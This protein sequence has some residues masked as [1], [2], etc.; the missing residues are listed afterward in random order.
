M[1]MTSDRSETDCP[2]RDGRRCG[3]ID[4]HDIEEAAG[5]LRAGKLV[6]FPTET[7]YGLGA[8]A[9]DNRA[10]AAIFEAKGRPRFNPL[11]VHVAD[12]AQ[13]SSLAVWSALAERLAR[14]FWPGP[15]TLILP[16]PQDSSISML[17]SAGGDTIALRAPAHPVAEELLRRT[18]LP[19]TGPSANPSGRV[20]PTTVDHVVQGL[21][22]R[23]DLVIDGGPCAVGVES[24][25][26]DLTTSRPCLLRPGGLP[27]EDIEAVIG[28]RLLI[29]SAQADGSEEQRSPGQLRSHY[30]P[31]HPVRLDVVDVAPDEALLAFGPEPLKGA[32]YTA[33]LS[34][35][36]D[37]REAASRLFAMLHDLDRQ[38]INGI[39]VMPVPPT[40][41]G[42]AI[43][44]RLKRAAARP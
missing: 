39:A 26:L 4:R 30:A 22:D 29:E 18:A 5:A 6:A 37:L 15:L 38:D 13:A 32:A 25:V 27:R 3:I 43:V 40:G 41:L 34:P 23:I 19:I 20:S 7:V 42:H 24:T 36:G 17:A 33:N 31:Q 16:R 9:N 10:V 2:R 44:D 35:T 21:G 11:I 1:A 28:E 12:L 14:H 8:N